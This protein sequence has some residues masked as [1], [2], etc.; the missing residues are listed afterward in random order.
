MIEETLEFHA[1]QSSE[2]R[3]NVK[4]FASLT[5]LKGLRVTIKTVREIVNNMFAAGRPYVLTGRLNQDC[6]EVMIMNSLCQ[7]RDDYLM[8]INFLEIFRINTSRRWLKGQTNLHVLSAT[9]SFV[10]ALLSDEGNRS[11]RKYRGI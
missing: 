4:T 1:Q 11:W 3:K 9:F 6:L 5:T 10:D 7:I 2:E 8:N